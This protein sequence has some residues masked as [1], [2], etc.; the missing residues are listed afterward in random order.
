MISDTT[1][2][3]QLY[4]NGELVINISLSSE[5]IATII[6]IIEDIEQ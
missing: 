2:P 4:V 6:K 3:L 1:W 5:S